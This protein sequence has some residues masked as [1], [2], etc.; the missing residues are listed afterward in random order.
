MHYISGRLGAGAR[1]VVE[2]AFAAELARTGS[3]HEALKAAQLLMVYGPEFHATN[4]NQ[5]SA[6]PRTEEVAHVPRRQP[7]PYKAIVYLYL[8]GACDSFNLLVPYGDCNG[9][10]LYE[11]YVEARTN[12]AL[13]KSQL[14]PLKVPDGTQPCDTF[15]VHGSLTVNTT[16][17]RASI[18][19]PPFDFFSLLRIYVL[20]HNKITMTTPTHTTGNLSLY[21][22]VPFSSSITRQAVADAY[23]AGDAAFIANIGPL[24]EPISVQEYNDK[25]KRRPGSLFA[26][27]LQTKVSK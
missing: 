22:S 8:D 9:T 25:S 7:L 17:I 24:V 23:D 5:A 10:D 12:V 6:E 2:D 27:N 18:A 15:S 20:S 19:F 4:V 13:P 14:L 11:E 3:K 16:K 21:I 26:H 1:R